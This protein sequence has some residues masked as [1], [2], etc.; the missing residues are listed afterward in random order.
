MWSVSSWCVLFN[1][2]MI[3]DQQNIKHSSIF[4]VLIMFVAFLNFVTYT[5]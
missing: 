1:Y 4:C 2:T 3:D 5:G